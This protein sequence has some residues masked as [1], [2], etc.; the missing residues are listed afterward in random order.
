MKDGSK[1]NW[2]EKINGT[3]PVITVRDY[4]HYYSRKYHQFDTRKVS[5]DT[6]FSTGSEDSNVSYVRLTPYGELDEDRIDNKDVP[7]KKF[8]RPSIDSLSVPNLVDQYHGKITYSTNKPSDY[9]R[10]DN[11]RSYEKYHHANSQKVA[12]INE[13]SFSTYRN[14][15]ALVRNLKCESNIYNIRT[16]KSL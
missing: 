3:T 16:Q 4:E 7:S 12:N 8:Q 2:F 9:Q 14:E 10:N 5:Q 13:V 11:S 15:E 6:L 1:V